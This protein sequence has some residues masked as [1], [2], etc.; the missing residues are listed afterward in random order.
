MTE[1]DLASRVP[2]VS[3]RAR[4]Y[5]LEDN[6]ASDL[7]RRKRDVR[8]AVASRRRIIEAIEKRQAGEGRL[9][10]LEQAEADALLAKHRQAIRDLHE[11]SSL[12]PAVNVIAPVGRRVKRE[13]RRRNRIATRKS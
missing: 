9:P 12:G 2:Q 4:V 7:S 3:T 5:K 6:G 10:P 11:H 13:D 1:E 8:D